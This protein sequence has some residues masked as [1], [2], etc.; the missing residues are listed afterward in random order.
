MMLSKSAPWR[1]RST[2]KS[3]FREAWMADGERHALDAGPG[4]SYGAEKP[5]FEKTWMLPD[6]DALIR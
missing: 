5:L 4:T 6:I 1:L 3:R 2:V